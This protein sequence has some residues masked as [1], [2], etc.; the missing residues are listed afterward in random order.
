MSFA[1]R[2]TQP[3]SVPWVG[4]RRGDPARILVTLER[5][6]SL[7][8]EDDEEP[9]ADPNARVFQMELVGLLT[10]ESRDGATLEQRRVRAQ[11]TDAARFAGT[12]MEQIE[13]ACQ[14]CPGITVAITRDEG[15]IWDPVRVMLSTLRVDGAP[16]NVYDVVERPPLTRE[17]LELT[18]RARRKTSLAIGT[19]P[20]PF[21]K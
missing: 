7:V 20:P 21:F 10:V 2:I 11:A 4:A 6:V 12:V 19:A 13:L 18:R 15:G 8:V 9:I 1:P 14:L 17:D 5:R 3:M 16:V